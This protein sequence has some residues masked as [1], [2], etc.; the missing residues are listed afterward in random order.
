MPTGASTACR[1]REVDGIALH[2]RYRDLS[3]RDL[4]CTEQLRHVTSDGEM[5][6]RKDTADF[7]VGAILEQERKDGLLARGEFRE[8][9]DH[10]STHSNWFV[11]FNGQRRLH[12]RVVG[13][14]CL[15]PCQGRRVVRI[16]NCNKRHS[17]SSLYGHFVAHGPALLS[18]A[19]N[20]PAR[21]IAD[22]VIS[23]TA[24]LIPPTKSSLPSLCCIVP[25]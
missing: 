15:Q 22:A 2:K 14:D 18:L 17:G 16:D 6:D 21:P 19:A 20:N 8:V 9:P 11:N 24:T 4:K 25:P 5:G 3:R 12:E 10:R 7:L 23:A 13:Q 1:C